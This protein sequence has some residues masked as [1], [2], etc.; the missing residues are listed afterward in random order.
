VLNNRDVAYTKQGKSE[1]PRRDFE[2]AVRVDP[3]FE[4]A[5]RNLEGIL[6]LL[7]IPSAL[8]LLGFRVCPED[9]PCLTSG[10]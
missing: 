1:K 10:H 8:S 6:S 3:A 2:E 4:Q 5:R 9:T 7:K